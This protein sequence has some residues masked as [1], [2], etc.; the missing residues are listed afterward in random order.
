VA[1]AKPIART[2][3][4]ARPAPATAAPGDDWETF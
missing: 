4:A 3:P 2:E 1:A